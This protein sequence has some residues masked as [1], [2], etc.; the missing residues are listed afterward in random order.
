MSGATPRSKMN[1]IALTGAGCL[2]AG[3]ALSPVVPIIMKLWTT[4]YAL[5]ATGWACLL[6]LFFHA[7]TDVLQSRRWTFPLVVIGTNAL[8]AYLLPTL[9][10]VRKMVGTFTAP[11]AGHLGA[12]GPVLS[13]GAVVLAG[14]LILYWLHRRRIFL[15]G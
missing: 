10:P 3:Y 8:A 9:V 12:L 11:A 15:S 2:A 4:S 14:W 1:V 5:V 13:T 6:F 7:V